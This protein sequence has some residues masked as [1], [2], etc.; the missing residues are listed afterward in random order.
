MIQVTDISSLTDFKRNS[1]DA[2]KRL[3]ESGQPQILTVNGHAEVVVQDVAAYQR[4]LDLVE[5]AEAIEGIR[6]GLESAARGEGLTAEEVFAELMAR[7][8]RP[9]SP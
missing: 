6:R 5:R 3:R 7:N 9:T 1:T 4:L 8:R 2:I